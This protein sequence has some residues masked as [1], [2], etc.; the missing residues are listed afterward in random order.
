MSTAYHPPDRWTMQKE[1]SGHV[2]RYVIAQKC[3]SSCL[4]GNEARRLLNLTSPEIIHETIEKIVQIK[5][6]IQAARD[7]QKS[8]A[9]VR[10]N[11]L[12]FKK[13][14]ELC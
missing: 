4:L 2:R 10:R 14:T 11:P 12:E 5:Q 9:D 3:R 6:R 7:R 1:P 13:A 8:Y